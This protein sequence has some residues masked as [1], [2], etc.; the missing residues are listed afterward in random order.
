LAHTYS[1]LQEQISQLEAQNAK[2]REEA[3]GARAHELKSVIDRAVATIAEYGITAAQLGFK[4]NAGTKEPSAPLP[5]TYSDGKGN[6][7]GGR[8]KRPNWLRQALRDGKEI[9]QFRL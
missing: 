5:A 7:W 1:Q 2:L 4:A 8:G 3:A 6:T 9:A